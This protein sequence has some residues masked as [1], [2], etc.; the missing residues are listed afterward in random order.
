MDN[1]RDGE[2]NK[3]RERGRETKTMTKSRESDNAEIE[4]DK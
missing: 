1:E 4:R 3:A 2:T